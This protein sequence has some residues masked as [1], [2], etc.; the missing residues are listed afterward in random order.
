MIK[1]ILLNI[2]VL[3]GLL[4]IDLIVPRLETGFTSSGHYLSALKEILGKGGHMDKEPKK[5][6]IIAFVVVIAILIIIIVF[7]PTIYRFM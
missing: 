1:R 6:V 2:P 3:L 4:A 7:L 5:S